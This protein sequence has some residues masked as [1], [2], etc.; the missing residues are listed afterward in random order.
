[1]IFGK[2]RGFKFSETR[3]KLKNLKKVFRNITS[4]LKIGSFKFSGTEYIYIYETKSNPQ[5]TKIKTW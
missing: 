2:F 5:T 4:V 1:M 3:Y